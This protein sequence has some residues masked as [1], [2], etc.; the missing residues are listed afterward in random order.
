MSYK[1]KQQ[2]T[3]LKNKGLEENRDFRIV[4][5]GTTAEIKFV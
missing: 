4:W 1:Q 2:I 5:F 3:V